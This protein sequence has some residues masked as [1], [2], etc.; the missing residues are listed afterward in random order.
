MTE[1]VQVNPSV[2]RL[3]DAPFIANATLSG[4]RA[5]CVA[6]VRRSLVAPE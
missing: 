5:W 2:H 1:L 6:W 4:W 3:D